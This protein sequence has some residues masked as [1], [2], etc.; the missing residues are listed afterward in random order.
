MNHRGSKCQRE[1]A[2]SAHGENRN[3]LSEFLETVRADA[4][5][6][7]CCRGSNHLLPGPL[8]HK[9]PSPPPNP[10]PLVPGS[11]LPCSS[12]HQ[13]LLECIDRQ[14][15]S[16]P[17]VHNLPAGIKHLLMPSRR[18][19]GGIVLR[20]RFPKTLHRFKT[21]GLAHLDDFFRGDHWR[22]LTWLKEIST[23]N[24]QRSQTTT[25]R[26][27]AGGFFW[28]A[29]V[30]AVGDGFGGD[31]EGARLCRKWCGRCCGG[32]RRRFSCGRRGIAR[33]S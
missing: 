33:L 12:A 9:I 23:R 15:V 28:D 25:D 16:F 29:G 27:I 26:K 1:T 19:K 30:D 4:T 14:P 24:S 18:G 21:F 6:P 8:S 17:R 13:P 7:S 31:A 10:G 11:A 5:P 32:R 3:G 2:E 20:K 22:R